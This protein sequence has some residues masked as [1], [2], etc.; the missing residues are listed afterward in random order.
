MQFFSKFLYC[1]TAGCWMI[2]DA[3]LNMT[4]LQPMSVLNFFQQAYQDILEQGE[5]EFSCWASQNK[6]ILGLA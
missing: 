5:D 4:F 3:D 1:D 2:L 6:I